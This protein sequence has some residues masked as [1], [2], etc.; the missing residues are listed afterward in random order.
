MLN[1][2]YIV[3]QSFREVEDAL[4]E[5]QTIAQ[6]LQAV[7]RQKKAAENAVMLSHERYHEGVT[8]YLEVLDSDRSQ[9]NADLAATETY[10]RYLNAHVKLF[11]ALGGGWISPEEEKRSIEEEKNAEVK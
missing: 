10:Q 8:S 7:L 6:E 9:F 4:V 11:K 1:Y 3:L 5:I 2:E